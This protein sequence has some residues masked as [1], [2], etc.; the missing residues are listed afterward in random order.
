L[1]HRNP[2]FSVALAEPHLLEGTFNGGLSGICGALA[3]RNILPMLVRSVR[4]RS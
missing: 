3:I 4:C 1:R 2:S